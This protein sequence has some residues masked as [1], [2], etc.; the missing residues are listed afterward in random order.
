MRF[1]LD[2]NTLS[3]LMKGERS[4]F[5]QLASRSRT[6]VLLPQPVVAEIEYGLSRLPRSKRRDRLRRR[7]EIF[8]RELQR[9]HWTDDV[10]QAFGRSKADLERRG[11]RIEDFDVAIAAHAL[12]G[13]STLVTAD[14]DHMSRVRGLKVENWNSPTARES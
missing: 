11:I 8:L 13:D 10:S 1:V 2:T 9:A 14:L 4:V 5:Q 7:F 12:A 6:D 3:S